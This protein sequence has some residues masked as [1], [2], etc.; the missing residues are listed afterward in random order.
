MSTIKLGTVPKS[1]KKVVSFPM[2]DGSTGMIEAEFRYR[3]RDQ[4]GSFIDGLVKDAGVQADQVEGLG[5]AGLMKRTT[6][7]N[8]RYLMDILI[9]WNLPDELTLDNARA[10]SNEVPAAAAALMET[11]RTAV[12]EGRLGN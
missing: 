2:L 11:Y 3:T 12:T 5:M 9:G 10:L 7:Q 8:G 6:D 1:F 4:F